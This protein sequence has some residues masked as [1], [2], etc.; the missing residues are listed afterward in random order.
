MPQL[1]QEVSVC[2]PD[3]R[4]RIPAGGFSLI[5]EAILVDAIAEQIIPSDEWPGGKRFRSHQLYR[6]TAGRTI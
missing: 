1:V 5:D 2:C 4:G 6:Q 3:V